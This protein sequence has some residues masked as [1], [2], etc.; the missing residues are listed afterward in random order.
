MSN[1]CLS[2]DLR[3][4]EQLSLSIVRARREN[5][6]CR[7]DQARLRDLKRHLWQRHP[8]YMNRVYGDRS[9]PRRGRSTDFFMSGF[10]VMPEN[11]GIKREVQDEDSNH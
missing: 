5:A 6:D 4:F 7:E 8:Y 2:R 10:A 11:G 3:Q 1:L 9:L